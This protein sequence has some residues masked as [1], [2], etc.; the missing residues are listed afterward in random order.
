MAF[1]EAALDQQERLRRG[2]VGSRAED[3]ESKKIA[4]VVKNSNDETFDWTS[5]TEPEINRQMRTT[6]MNR[7]KQNRA[8]R[9]ADWRR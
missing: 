4:G 3:L 7:M 8:K 9:A 6:K 2:G 1:R 5:Q